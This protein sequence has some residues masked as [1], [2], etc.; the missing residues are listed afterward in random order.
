MIQAVYRKKYNRV[1]ISGHAHSGEP[2]RDL[3]CAGASTLAVTL[4]TNVRYMAE[5]GYVRDPVIE[6]ESG[7]ALIQCTP[8][9]RFRKSVE[10]VMNSVCVGFEALALQYPEHISYEVRG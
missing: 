3:I 10:Q 5:M 1:K 7:E 8:E 4:A 9:R 6:L 2:G